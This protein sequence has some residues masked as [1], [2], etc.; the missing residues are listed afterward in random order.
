[1]H[2]ECDTPPPSCM[3]GG[4]SRLML[5]P[6]EVACAAFHLRSPSAFASAHADACFTL[7]S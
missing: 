3:I 5:I 4:F 1:M 2:I 6:N 7:L